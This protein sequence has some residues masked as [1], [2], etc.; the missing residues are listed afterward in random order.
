[1]KDIAAKYGLKIVRI[2]THIGSGSDPAIWQSVAVS[3]LNLVR[4]FPDV[5]TLN[6]GGGYKVCTQLSTSIA[7]NIHISFLFRTY[8][9]CKF[10]F[11]FFLKVGRMSYEVSTDLQKIGIPVKEA[12][13]SFANEDGRK[14]K[15]EIEPGTYLVANAG[16]VL[17]TV[18]DI[19][20]TG[21]SGNTFIKL[22]SGMTEVLRP[23]L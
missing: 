4:E 20:S 22:D 16:A 5:C 8:I 15:L 11:F 3:S 13:E 9:F 6:L 10:H 17:C 1:M 18:R 19:V 2:H 7:S 12:F 23:S 21:P 14:L